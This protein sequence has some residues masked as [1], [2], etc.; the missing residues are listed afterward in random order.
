M[1]KKFIMVLAA[2][3]LIGVLIALAVPVMSPDVDVGAAGAGIAAEVA[4]LDVMTS[5]AFGV[6]D[7]YTVP[8]PAVAGETAIWLA[9]GASLLTIAVACR[10]RLDNF[11]A[12]R[13]ISLRYLSGSIIEGA[14][15]GAGTHPG[16]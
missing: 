1:K 12:L 6:L 8:V 5:G 13:G 7:N 15:M 14:G 2:I 4:D 10:R 3:T 9:L 11:L 16:I